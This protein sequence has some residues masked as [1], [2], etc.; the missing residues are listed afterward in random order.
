[1]A[2]L[3]GLE[4]GVEISPRCLHVA[5]PLEADREV[6]LPAGVAGIGLRQALGEVPC[7]DEFDVRAFQ[8]AA[9]DEQITDADTSP[10]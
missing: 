1:M 4:R 6:A 9:L 3:I 5:D 10:I 8:I 2:V 7:L